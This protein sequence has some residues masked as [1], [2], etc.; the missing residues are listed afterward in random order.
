MISYSTPP[1]FPHGSDRGINTSEEEVEAK[2]RQVGLVGFKERRLPLFGPRRRRLLPS[3]Q[4]FSLH[5]YGS[6]QSQQQ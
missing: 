2:I 1:T 3:R 6:Q 4:T 5:R